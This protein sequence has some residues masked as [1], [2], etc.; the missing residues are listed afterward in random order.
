MTNPNLI[1]L[2]KEKAKIDYIP[3]FMFLWVSLNAWMK[4]RFEFGD[5]RQGLERL[6]GSPSSLFDKF[7]DLI[8]GKNKN[9]ILFREYFSEL[10]QALLNAYIPY[11]KNS[12]R[13][14]SFKCCMFRYKD[15]K[16]RFES[17]LVEVGPDNSSLESLTEFSE[18]HQ[19][20]IKLDDRLT[21]ESDP[22]RL[23]DAYIEIVYQVRCSLFH[24]DLEPT[25]DEN[26]RVIRQLYLTLSMIMENI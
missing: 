26:K 23:F 15:E 10:H 25:S 22:Q 16:P 7:S 3:P 14:I 8:D 21:V 24:G 4:D 20:T 19:E 6:K 11:H 13:I 5:E 1:K 12:D 18:L 9:A 2:W 17:I